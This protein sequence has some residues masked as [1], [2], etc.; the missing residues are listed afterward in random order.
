MKEKSENEQ[1][2]VIRTDF[3][4]PAEWAP[5]ST[6]IQRFRLEHDD[7]EYTKVLERFNLT[8]AGKYEIIRIER[9]QNKRWYTA[10]KT[11]LDYS[12]QL[13]TEEYLFHGCPKTS[14]DMIINT[15]FNRSFAGVNGKK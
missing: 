7:P 12:Q 4:T 2:T 8:M 5:Q 3:Q 9:I 13:E 6:D 15:C 10:Y 1:R 14:A 11:F